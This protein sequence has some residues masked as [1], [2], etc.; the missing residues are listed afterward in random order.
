MN[1][2][3]FIKL[4]TRGNLH[5]WVLNEQV[6]M[7]FTVTEKFLSLGFYSK[8]GVYDGS[9][10]LISESTEAINWAADLFEYYRRRSDKIELRRL[11][12]LISHLI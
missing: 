9:R 2:K 7:A 4:N 8:D 6:N 3:H 11:D 12:K 1:L 10:D 5:L